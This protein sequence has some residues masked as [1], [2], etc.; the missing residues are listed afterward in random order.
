MNRR[1][2][3]HCPSRGRRGSPARSG[4]CGPRPGAG[5]RPRGIRGGP[6][7]RP[8]RTGASRARAPHSVPESPRGLRAGGLPQARAPPH[9][10][11][12]PRRAADRNP[13][14]RAAR[15]RGRSEPT[16]TGASSA[17]AAAGTAVAAAAAG[18]RTRCQAARAPPAP[19]VRPGTRIR[20]RGPAGRRPRPG[21][22]RDTGGRPCRLPRAEY[23]A[24]PCVS[25]SAAKRR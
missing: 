25:I 16:R 20:P 17:M 21:S 11:P 22:E 1:R 6:G 18:T 15:R 2:P 5:P 8:A 13:G 7:R 24:T 12:S 9:I 19:A 3:P 23:E 10:P 4:A 14:T